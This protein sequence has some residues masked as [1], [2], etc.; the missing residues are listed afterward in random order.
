MGDAMV[1]ARRTIA[2]EIHTTADRY[3]T[4]CSTVPACYVCWAVAEELRTVA[5][6][7]AQTAIQREASR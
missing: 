4:D 5:Y 6:Q 7:L 3:L 2:R 1:D